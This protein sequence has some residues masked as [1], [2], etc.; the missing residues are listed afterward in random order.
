MRQTK[1]VLTDEDRKIVEEMKNKGRHASR[2]ITRA[3]ILSSLDSGVSENELVNVLKIG[4]S[5]IYRTRKS[6]I[7]GGLDKALFDESRPG[8][9]IRYGDDVIALI[10]A[11][12]CSTPPEGRARWTIRLLAEEAEKQLNVGHISRE[13]VRRALKKRAKTMTS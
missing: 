11:L 10:V 2:E 3:I 5:T 8:K 12:T 4:R 6:Y 1:L 13:T 9:P 7:D